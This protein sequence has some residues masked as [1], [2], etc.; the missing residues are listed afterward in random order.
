LT[1][2]GPQPTR[3]GLIKL[4]DG[5]RNKTVSPMFPPLTFGGSNRLGIDS[6][7]YG[8]ARRAKARHRRQ[9]QAAAI[10]REMSGP[11]CA[12]CHRSES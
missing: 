4:L 5:W 9:L 1:D 12:R 10:R 7:Y 8:A 2:L 3:A 6:M 11:R